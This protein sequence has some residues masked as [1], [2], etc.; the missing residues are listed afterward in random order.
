MT[1]A[2]IE[3][4]AGVDRAS[5]RA[6]LLSLLWFGHWTTDLSRPLSP[7]LRDADRAGRRVTGAS[8]DL[9]VG[10][11]VWLDGQGWEVAELTGTSAR[12]VADGRLRTVSITSLIGTTEPAATTGRRR[13]GRVGIL[14]G[15]PVGGPFRPHHQAGRRLTAKLHALRQVIEPDPDDARTL[16]RYDD[17]AAALGVSRRTL[18][19]QVARLGSSARRAWWTR[20]CCRRSAGQSTCDGTASAWRCCPAT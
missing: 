16:P 13:G 6:A 1:L 4:R 14:V 7:Q 9:R 3:P 15:D 10:G 5:A 17:T 11:R 8:F 20:E 2:Q 19:R 12:L 18:E